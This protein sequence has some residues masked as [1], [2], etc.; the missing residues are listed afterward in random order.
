MASYK[1][2]GTYQ[3]LL[4]CC[5]CYLATN[6]RGQCRLKLCCLL[7]Q[8]FLLKVPVLRKLQ[9]PWYLIVSKRMN[10]VVVCTVVCV[11]CQVDVVA[12]VSFLFPTYCTYCTYCT[13]STVF[14]RQMTRAIEFEIGNCSSEYS[15][16]QTIQ[17]VIQLHCFQATVIMATCN[18]S[19]RVK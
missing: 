17:T 16:E 6:P 12:A 11:K 18:P 2:L 10:E 15:I 7:Q 1:Y 9:V 3:L 5:N 8:R 13:Y 14:Y 4:I 19:L